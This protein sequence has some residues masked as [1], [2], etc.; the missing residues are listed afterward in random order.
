MT[1]YRGKWRSRAVRPDAYA[2]SPFRSLLRDCILDIWPISAGTVLLGEEV[3]QRRLHSVTSAALESGVGAALLD[4]FLI[5]A[6]A[7][8]ADDRRPHSR[9]TFDA[10]KFADLLREIPTLVGPNAML[11]AMGATKTELDKL[12]SEGLVTPR[13]KL[14]KVKSP[15][16]I[17]DGIELVSRLSEMAEPL[18]AQDKNWETI[19]LASGRADTSIGEI[20][21]AVQDGH[22]KLGQREGNNG[23]H[24]FEVHIPELLNWADNLTHQIKTPK[25]LLPGAMSAAAFGRSV[26]LRDRGR[27]EA[28]VANGHTP[29]FA[30]NNPKTHRTQWQ[31]SEADIEAFHQKFVTAATIEAIFELHPN[32]FQAIL[33]AAGCSPFAPGGLDFGAIWLREVVEPVLLRHVSQ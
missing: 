33:R 10:R 26:G 9:K 12:A 14:P 2:F 1:S 22:L 4:Q 7:F 25:A 29:A 17:E 11:Q 8:P 32:T 24:A 30:I 27:F 18:G 21:G 15:W 5:E 28:L 13:T 23:Y 31:V 20:I 16:R 6:H 3:P 19:Q